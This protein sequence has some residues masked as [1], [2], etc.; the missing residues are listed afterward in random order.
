MMASLEE[1]LTCSVCRDTFG[2]A[3][4]LPCGHSLCPACT[5]E[6]WA[7]QSGD[8]GHFTCPQC[9]EEHGDVL[10]DCCSPDAEGGQV[11]IAVKTCLRCEVSLCGQHL[12]PHLERPAFST[13]LL[14]NPLGDISKRRCPTH[15]EIFRYYCADERVYICSDCLLEGSHAQHKVKALRQVEED[16]K[17]ILQTLLQKAEEKL[18]NG[19]RILKEYQNVDR[20]MAESSE[21]DEAQ[22]E[23]LGS[24]LQVQV[25][26][27]VVALREITKRQRQQAVERLQE[28]CSKVKED[29][30]Q[31]QSTQ[32]YLAS[33][34]AA[35]DPFLLIWAFQSDDS[36]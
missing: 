28:D 25:R 13:H 24:S 10:C 23:R 12:Q 26:S 6:A 32:H 22:V 3:H 29:L 31:T 7:G 8:K 35:T 33:L 36:K 34:L 11:P 18:Q 27:L 30:S 1:E 9:Q 15:T 21:V 4:P 20:N 17:V 5:R 14:V 19:E 16:L 2:Q